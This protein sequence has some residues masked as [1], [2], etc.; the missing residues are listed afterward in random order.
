[1]T[2]YQTLARTHWTRYAPTR[3]E[4]IPN[5]DEFFQM[6]GQQVHEQVTELTVQLAGQDRAGESYLE[7]VGRLGAARLRAEEIVL[8]ELVW[9]SSPETSPAEAREAWELDR[10]SDSW[11]TSWAERIQESPEDQMPA[12]EELVDLAAEWM[13]P[14]TF[15][16]ALLEAEYPAQFLREHQ[17]TLAQAAERRYHRS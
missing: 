5:P 13:L 3:V 14:V 4:A 11:L 12:T 9:I 1:M 7:K 15:L 16:Q 17:E 8:T 2:H 6:L 10:T